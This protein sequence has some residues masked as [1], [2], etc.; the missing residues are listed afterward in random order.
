MPETK[1]VPR[2]A[3]RMVSE[4][5]FGDNGAESKTVH[6]LVA[7]MEY[8]V[9]LGLKEDGLSISGQEHVTVRSAFH[10]SEA[11]SFWG[12]AWEPRHLTIEFR[13]SS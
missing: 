7:D 12:G 10:S 13:K 11:F 1:N 4:V 5:Q 9:D 8:F 6:L 3:C 2:Q